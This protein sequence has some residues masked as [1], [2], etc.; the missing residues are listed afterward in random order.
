M[1]DM[2]ELKTCPCCGT[3]SDTVERRRMN[4]AYADEESNYLT[5]CLA[6]FEMSEDY[7]RERWADYYGGLL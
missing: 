2:P 6:C 3:V 7:W 4:T 5:S 1:T